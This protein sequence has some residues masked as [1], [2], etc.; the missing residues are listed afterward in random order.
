MG[1]LNFTW[2]GF[3][4]SCLL[5]VN[6]HDTWKVIFFFFWFVCIKNFVKRKYLNH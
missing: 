6:P 5:V 1:C 4:V 3:G 2:H